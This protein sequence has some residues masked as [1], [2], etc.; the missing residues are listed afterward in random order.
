MAPPRKRPD[1]VQSR[2]GERKKNELKV[3]QGG[4]ASH[5]AP[6][7]GWA[8]ETAASYEAFWGSEVANVVKAEHHHSILRLFEMR[9]LQAR[10][11]RRYRDLPYVDGSMGQPVTNPAFAEATKLETQITALEDRLGLTPK[12]MANLGIAVGQAALTA[13]DLNNMAGGAGADSDDV[14]EVEGW[15]A[16]D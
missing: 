3:L 4:Q 1:L 16:V 2:G 13:A 9:D 15:E 10:A 6:L 5:P 14:L 12:A 11:L 7:E 8:E